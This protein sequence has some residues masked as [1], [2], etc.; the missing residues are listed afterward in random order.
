MLDTQIKGAKESTQLEGTKEGEK[1]KEEDHKIK[2]IILKFIKE[3]KVE[4]FFYV[5]FLLSFPISD[6]LLP[7]YYGNIMEN[8]TDTENVKEN[9]KT[10]GYLMTLNLFLEKMTNHLDAIFKP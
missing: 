3:H 9:V 1:S 4:I 8:I 5:I 2:N 7:K 10:I 6:V